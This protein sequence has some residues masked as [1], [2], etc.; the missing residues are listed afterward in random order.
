M[1][2]PTVDLSAHMNETVHR[3][4]PADFP[5]TLQPIFHRNGVEPEN[6]PR[7]RAV[8]RMDTG[9]TLAV[10]SDRYRLIPHQRILDVVDESLQ[11]LDVGPV[12]R[13]I[14]IDRKGARMR[15]VFKFPS[16][17]KPV[18]GGDTICP[19]LEL[20]NTY[21]GTSR[22]GIH[23]GAFRFVCTNLAVGGGGAFAGGFLSTHVGEI[24]LD[25]MAA[26]LAGYL[27]AFDRIVALY[28]TWA[29]QSLERERL[30]GALV[31]LPKKA[32]EAIRAETQ[33]RGARV[34][35]EAYNVATDHATHRTRSVRTAF[36]LLELVNQG[37]QEQFPSG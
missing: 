4:H 34:V 35:F 26:Q 8:V 31:G 13:G 23:I 1:A 3:G 24:P 28:R 12:P 17:A 9:E 7:R 36:Q 14:Y 15:A 32:G 20:R 33:R 19:C 6:I 37:F 2:R 25:E 11:T 30:E 16:L 21:D 18:V 5:V 22:I 29:R 10:V 27:S